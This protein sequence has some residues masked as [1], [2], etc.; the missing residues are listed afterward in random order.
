ML[1]ESLYANKSGYST[2]SADF[3]LHCGAFALGVLLR[4]FDP[5][6]MFCRL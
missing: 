4:V 6:T 1:N 3:A 2:W 5:I